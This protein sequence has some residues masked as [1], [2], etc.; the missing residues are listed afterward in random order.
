MMGKGKELEFSE[1]PGGLE[2]ASRILMKGEPGVPPI[3]AIAV[4]QGKIKGRVYFLENLEDDTVVLDIH[5]EGLKKNGVHGFHV[6]ECG[7][8][9]DQCES[10]CAHFNPYGK[11]HGGP[12]SKERHVGDLGNI[13]ANGEGVAHGRMVDDHIRLR[14]TKANIIGRGLIIHADPDDLGLG[15][16]KD[17]LTTGHA[18]KRIACAVIG[19]ARGS[20]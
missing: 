8:M 11:S 17:S 18:G 19:Y 15:G 1:G 7:D 3:R 13:E 6:H 5:I 20:P 12:L 4:F 9:S 2:S 10:M 16:E 14:G